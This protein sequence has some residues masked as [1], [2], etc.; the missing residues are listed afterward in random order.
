M[1]IIIIHCS[2][3]EYIASIIVHLS[4]CDS[5]HV[6]IHY[7]QFIIYLTSSEFGILLGKTI[8]IY[9][10]Y[11]TLGVN[12]MGNIYISMTH[13]YCFFFNVFSFYRMICTR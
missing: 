6:S 9:I 3:S 13:S 5:V 2:T 1:I 11:K 4:I 7:T 8:Y 10:G 12:K